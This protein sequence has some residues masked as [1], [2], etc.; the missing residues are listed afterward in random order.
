M[1]LYHIAQIS[2]KRK[3]F[4]DIERQCKAFRFNIIRVGITQKFLTTHYCNLTIYMTLRVNNLSGSTSFDNKVP[5]V[6][7]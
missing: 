4:N 2:R 7:R 5:A 6:Q 1:A 3:S